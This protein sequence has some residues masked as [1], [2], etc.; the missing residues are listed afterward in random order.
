MQPHVS[1]IL[2][3]FNAAKTLERSLN[4]IQVQ[5]LQNWEL[6]AIDDGSTDESLH[7]LKRYA[8]RD[9]RIVILEKPHSGIVDALNLGISKAQ[10]PYL[11]RM[12]ADDHMRPSRIEKQV[13]WLDEHPRTGLVSCLVAH[14]GT[15]AQQGYAHHVHWANSLQSHHDI[16][17]NRFVD[18]PLP[19]PSVMFRKAC[20]EKAGSYQKGNFPED[21]E[22]WLRWLEAGIIMEKVPEVLL[23]WY[24]S[25][26]RLS[27]TH[28]M[29][30]DEA[31]S[32]TKAPY[33]MHWLKQHNP[34]H[35]EVY[36]WGAGRKSRKRLEHLQKMG[37]L[38]KAFFDIKF[39]GR[40]LESPVF[41]YQ[42]IRTMERIFVLSIVNSRGGRENIKA[43][44]ETIGFSEGKSFILT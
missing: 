34:Y 13:K 15:E 12:D 33:L 9:S 43:Y 2:P 8:Q 6:I 1:I 27:R 38:V 20:V 35:P 18:S 21:Y 31:F 32:Q 41:D 37:L 4:S 36:V 40:Q 17:L 5:S 26:S 3:I 14:Q 19:H 39:A 16:Q 42:D 23:D 24:D 29:Y 44:L 28:G 25:P 22:L 7:V 11:A 10:A 30:S